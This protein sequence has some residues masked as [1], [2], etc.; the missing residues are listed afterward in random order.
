MKLGEVKR[1]EKKRYPIIQQKALG[2][3]SW[4]TY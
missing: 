1:D 2:S 4:I 3:D